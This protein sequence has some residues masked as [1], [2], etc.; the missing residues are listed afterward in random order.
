[1]PRRLKQDFLA[2]RGRGGKLPRS[3][4]ISK[5]AALRLLDAF[6]RYAN[7]L[8]DNNDAFTQDLAEHIAANPATF[9][10]D[11]LIR[12]RERLDEVDRAAEADGFSQQ[13]R[14]FRI[15]QVVEDAV[16]D[17]LMLPGVRRSRKAAERRR[18]SPKEPILDVILAE[19]PM[20]LEEVRR[21]W[22]NLKALK[23]QV[24]DNIKARLAAQHKDV[25]RRRIA[26]RLPKKFEAN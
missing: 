21:R 3:P 15:R 10:K 14:E 26:R 17:L 19:L 8:R 6:D 20:A 23:G 18:N 2:T 16:A 1:M 5:K 22:P 25:S 9:P 12:I 11:K 24:V 4:R 7:A 13:M